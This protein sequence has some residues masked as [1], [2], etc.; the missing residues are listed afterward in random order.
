MTLSTCK[1]LNEDI[2][3]AV[4]AKLIASVKR[5]TTTE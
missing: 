1:S 3:V 2:R 4:H 5:E